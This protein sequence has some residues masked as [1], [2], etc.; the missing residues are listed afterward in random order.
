MTLDESPL[1]F[2]ITIR[3]N[4]HNQGL[5][6]WLWNE[7]KTFDPNID[8]RATKR[9]IGL[10]LSKH[11]TRTFARVDDQRSG[12]LIGVEPLVVEQ[13]GIGTLPVYPIS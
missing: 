13:I 8:I 1:P 12:L 6:V 5:L 2:E 3:L 7:L 9:Y 11:D 4:G 10:Y